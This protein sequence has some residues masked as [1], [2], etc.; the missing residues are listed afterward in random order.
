[1]SACLSLSECQRAADLFGETPRAF[2]VRVVVDG[3]PRQFSRIDAANKAQAV[4]V[5]LQASGLSIMDFSRLIVE[6]QEVTQ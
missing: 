3:A 5:A 2:S 4:M 6:V 1:M